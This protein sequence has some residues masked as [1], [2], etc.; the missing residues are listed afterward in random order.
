MA[1]HRHRKGE[2]ART[3]QGHR[4]MTAPPGTTFV[5]TALAGDLV[6]AQ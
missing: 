4:N 2:E 3:A 1:G 6:G 5:E